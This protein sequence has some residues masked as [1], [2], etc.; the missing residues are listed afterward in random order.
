MGGIQ[1]IW[2]KLEER[3]KWK[4]K[5]KVGEKGEVPFNFSFLFHMFL[6][7]NCLLINSIFSIG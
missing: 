3:K 6:F 2:S 1:W 7:S 5:E 4:V